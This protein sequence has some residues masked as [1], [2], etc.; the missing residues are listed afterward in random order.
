MPGR[1][2]SARSL[3][4]SSRRASPGGQRRRSPPWRA[5]GG[6]PSPT[7]VWNMP[8]PCCAPLPATPRRKRNRRRHSPRRRSFSAARPRTSPCN[9]S[10]GSTNTAE[11]PRKRALTAPASC[12]IYTASSAT[13]WSAW[14]TI[15][16]SRARQSS[17]R[18]SC[19]AISSPFTPPENM[20]ATWGCTSAAGIISTRWARPTAW[21]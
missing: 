11:A 17:R 4:A 16:P 7:A 9:S 19:P 20:S 8:P 18:T 2:T 6:S 10:A 5:R 1:R 13:S 3:C 14:R 15:R 21:C 12:A